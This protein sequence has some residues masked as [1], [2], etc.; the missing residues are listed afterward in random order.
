MTGIPVNL[1]A[2]P[3]EGGAF[4]EW[5]G[6]STEHRVQI[7]PA[8]YQEI[9]AVF[10]TSPGSSREALVINEIMYHPQHT[11]QS[12]WIELYNPNNRSISLNGFQ[13]TDGGMG[14]RYLFGE[15]AVI[16]PR[17]YMVVVGN[18][19]LFL[20]EHGTQV[21][22]TGSF[23]DGDSG[24]R[25]SNDGESIILKNSDGELEDIVQY[26]DQAPWP[27]EADGT[28]PS[29]QLLAPDLDNNHYSSWFASMGVRSSPKN[30]GRGL[31]WESTP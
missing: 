3:D 12:E 17:G 18:S 5:R 28:G 19:E 29:L 16:D 11:G 10:D 7:D 30:Q 22:F 6:L 25:L 14:N 23:N 26:D 1:E 20:S 15:E 27:E 4:I 8:L 24:F 31:N 13:L 21:Y 2:W 9:V